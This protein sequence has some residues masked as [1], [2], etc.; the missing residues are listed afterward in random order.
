MNKKKNRKNKRK[1]KGKDEN[2]REE[3]SK[4]IGYY[5]EK[6]IAVEEKREIWVR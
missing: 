3:N 5:T 1:E 6:A 4:T 2:E